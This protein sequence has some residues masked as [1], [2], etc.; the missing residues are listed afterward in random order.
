MLFHFKDESLFDETVAVHARAAE[1][2]RPAEEVAEIYTRELAR[3]RVGARIDDYLVLLT[4]RYAQGALRRSDSRRLLEPVAGEP[5][6]RGRP[7][8]PPSARR[9]T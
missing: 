2:D 5:A 1:T 6:H 7:I 4:S 8:A 9:G 3:L